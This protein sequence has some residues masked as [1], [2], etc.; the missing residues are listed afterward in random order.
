MIQDKGLCYILAFEYQS[1]VSRTRQ[2]D[3][4]AVNFFH[5]LKITFGQHSRFAHGASAS[6]H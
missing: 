1:T 5:E 2:D 3:A 6:E 4:E